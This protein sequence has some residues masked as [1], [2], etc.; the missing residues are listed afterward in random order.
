[1]NLLDQLQAKINMLREQHFTD[2][3]ELEFFKFLSKQILT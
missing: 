1:M 3:D 2:E